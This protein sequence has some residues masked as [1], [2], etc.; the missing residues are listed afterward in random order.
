MADV[1]IVGCG[2]IGTRLARQWGQHNRSV[3]ALARSAASAERLRALGVEPHRGDLDDAATLHDLPLAG[4]LLYYL[5]PPPGTGQ[6]DSR[7]RHFVAALDS[8]APPHQLIYLSTSGV[9][10]DCAGA[11]VTEERPVN[12]Q[13]ARA[14][15]RVDAETVLGHWC[16]AHDVP[17]TILRVAG[18]Y[19]PERLPIARLQQ[20]RPVVREEEC[21]YT[22]RIH[23]EDLLQVCIAAA[24]HAR[25]IA[26]YN[27]S[28]G[29]PGTLSGY[30]FAVADAL[31]MERP[32]AITLEQA[33]RQLTPAMLSYLNESR[34]LDNRKLLRELGVS[35]RYPDLQSGLRGISV[36]GD[37]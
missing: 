33:R 24:R 3:G 30:F 34:R 2:N 11:W 21:G 18:I 36:T 32:V 26:I 15:R 4:S 7:M 23:L 5:A 10:G 8:T 27:V 13:A 17:L 28:D 25:G 29:H 1:F 35:L 37:N 14:R 6:H 19:G 20:G 9:Y 12:P 22:N 31:G 16:A